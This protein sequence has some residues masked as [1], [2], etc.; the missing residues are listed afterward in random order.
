MRFDLPSPQDLP[1]A[2][3][4]PQDFD[5]PDEAYGAKTAF[6]LLG[7]GEQLDPAYRQEADRANRTR[8][9]E[10]QN[11]FLDRQRQILHTGPDAFLNRTGRDAV[12]GADD[13]L[14]KL[15]AAPRETL[16]QAANG[17]QRKL[18]REALDHHATTEHYRIGGHVGEQSLQWQRQTA[19]ER[20]NQLLQQAAIDHGDPD[21]I[22]AYGQ[23][24]EGPARELARTLR[25]R[26]DS[27][28]TEGKV[29]AA[30]S[31]IWHHAIAAALEH[32]NL[33]AAIDLHDRA[34]DRLT[35]ADARRLA[36]QIAAAKEYRTAQ[37]YVANLPPAPTT[38]LDTAHL[39]ALAQND[40]DWLHDRS[41]HTTNQ[42]LIDVAFGQ[43][44]R[45]LLQEKADLNQAVDDWLNRAGQTRRPPFGLWV[46]LSSEERA[47][48]DETLKRNA[49]TSMDQARA[50]ASD[51]SVPTLPIRHL[52]SEL[53]ENLVP[54]AHYSKLA[55]TAVVGGRYGEG[56][57]YGVASLLDAALT[58]FGFGV[59]AELG[60]AAKPAIN[61]A[62]SAL[63][64]TFHEAYR[65]LE[66][67]AVAAG[68]G[69]RR[70]ATGEFSIID[71]TGYPGHLPKPTG[72]FRLIDG[73]EYKT[74]RD[75]ATK[76]NK[77]WHRRAPSLTGQHI[78]EVHSIKF[79]G[80][81]NDPLNKILL[82]AEEH[83]AVTAWWNKL[84]YY[85]ER[86]R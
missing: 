10:L 31:A 86:A 52:G 17:M 71:W 41:Q 83:N 21:S 24:S 59:G 68:I 14:A 43:R 19:R 66:E 81:P 51:E 13:V 2:P 56:A 64:R 16:D 25:Y 72:P 54:G 3:S 8:A 74:N 27:P 33:A 40:G 47:R 44:K 29:E 46:S 22:E 55:Q 57:V 48:V 6:G 62:R 82:S 49:E 75:L 67:A 11:Q 28:E 76:I 58:I 20:L 18:L 80:S 69:K 73:A 85:V 30:R 45:D 63:S 5:I 9:A 70:T 26:P 4:V 32:W 65:V 37:D 78:H 35:E 61:A 39:L 84:Q 23:A 53:L 38:H 34:S 1:P 77:A 15:D 7:P 50:L 42:H 12:L 60:A 79:G 36:P